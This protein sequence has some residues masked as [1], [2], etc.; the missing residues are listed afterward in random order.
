MNPLIRSLLTLASLT[1]ALGCAPSFEMG[2]PSRFVVLEA[3]RGDALSGY[4]Q[5]GTTPDG[6]VVG[7]RSIEHRVQGSLPFWSEAV[8]RRLRD[9]EG[10]AV[11]SEDS[12]EAANGQA[13]HLIRLGRDLNGHGYRY[14]VAVF[15]TPSHLWIAD[16]GG[17]AEPFT[18]MESEI[19]AAIA[20]ARF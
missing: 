17:R 4:V 6:V 20:A 15:A 18:E 19:E 7:L 11:L 10:Y 16:A 3:D 14:T 2:L 12:I 1:A 5:R 8:V 9:Q 13:G